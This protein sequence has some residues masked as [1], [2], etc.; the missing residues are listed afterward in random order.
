[1]RVLAAVRLSNLTDETTSP[2]RQKAEILGDQVVASGTL[3]DWAEDLDI[4]ADK[5]SPFKRPKL[6][7]W[8]NDRVGEYDALVF[9]KADRAIRSMMDMY[10]L[11]KWA[12]THRKVIVFVAGP[13]G[14]PRMQLDF[15]NGPLDPITQLIVTIFAFAGEIEVSNV[16]DRTRGSQ[17]LARG[18]GRW[19]GGLPPYGYRAVKQAKGDGWKLEPDPKAVEVIEGII[20]R[21]LRDESINSI[22]HVLN[23][24]GIPSPRDHFRKQNGKEVKNNKWT[25]AVVSGILKGKTLLGTMTHGGKVFRGKNGLPVKRADAVISYTTWWKVQEKLKSRTRN[26]IRTRST[27]PLL[28]IPFCLACGQP[29]YRYAADRERREYYR[30]RGQVSSLTCESKSVRG[31]TLTQIIESQLL[32][33]LGEREILE[34]VHIPGESHVEDLREATE[35]LSDLLIRSSGKPPA[36]KQIYDQQIAAL[37]ELIV[38]LSELPETSARVEYQSTGATYGQ[39]WAA[40]DPQER[41]ALLLK[42]GVRIEAAPASDSWVSVGRFDRPERYDHAVSLGVQDGIQY[43]FYL[44]SDLLS[45]ATGLSLATSVA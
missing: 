35:G 14:G 6:G 9:A 30:C 19:H 39:L 3:V 44:P 4:S 33:H 17:M 41:R 32:E 25:T 36:V 27:S 7:P 34:E 13:G 42:A 12:V 1:M 5:F 15:R 29:R 11:S 38:Q 31:D 18:Q 10:E 8:L 40:S 21:V 37:E 24:T 22:C 26:S 28:G 2:E 20:E 16:K 43:A 45:R 23:T